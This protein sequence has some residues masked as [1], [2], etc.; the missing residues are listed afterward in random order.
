[1][2]I[3]GKERAETGVTIKYF[4]RIHSLQHLCQQLSSNAA[5]LRAAAETRDSFTIKG[6]VQSHWICLSL[7]HI[8]VNVIFSSNP[9]N[10]GVKFIDSLILHSHSRKYQC[11]HNRFTS[12]QC[13]TQQGKVCILC[14]C[15]FLTTNASIFCLQG[16]AAHFI[17]KDQPARMYQL[18]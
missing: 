17:N 8:F 2:A 14:G 3:E 4:Q 12:C 9:I 16:V 1:M 10:E 6:E 15:L 5:T 18:E 11:A 7:T 13:K